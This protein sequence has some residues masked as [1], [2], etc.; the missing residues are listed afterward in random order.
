MV[1]GYGVKTK[2]CIAWL[3]LLVVVRLQIEQSMLT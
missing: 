3:E 1:E 2:F